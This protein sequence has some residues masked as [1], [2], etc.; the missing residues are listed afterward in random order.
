MVST[1]VVGTNTYAT[2]AESNTYLGDSIDSG[3]WDFLGDDDKT[4]AL[5][6]AFRLLEKQSY[7]GTKT[8]PL[9]TAAFPRT[10]LSCHGAA[11]DSVTVPEDVESAQIELAYALS[12]DPTLATQANTGTNEKRL[13]AGSASIEFFNSTDGSG[14]YLASRFPAN[15]QELLNCDLASSSSTAG[16]EAF[17]TGC[18]SIFPVC[19]PDE[20]GAAGFNRADP[21]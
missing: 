19:C 10:G 5:I 1:L 16:A 11:V 17:G 13:Q 20:D 18:P 14:G 3:N 15:V 2:L 21:F 6:S 8:D 12:Q 9:Q 7:S 4:K